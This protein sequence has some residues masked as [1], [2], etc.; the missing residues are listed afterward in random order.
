MEEGKK[1]EDEREVN[2]LLL[3]PFVQ[4]LS[5]KRTHT[6]QNGPKAILVLERTAFLT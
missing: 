6:R 1:D 4:R 3:F 5:V 2:K